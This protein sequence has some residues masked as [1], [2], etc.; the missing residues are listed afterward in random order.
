M[1]REA[2][3]PAHE[4]EK[5]PVKQE[6][7]SENVPVIKESENEEAIPSYR[8]LNEWLAAMTANEHVEDRDEKKDQL[9]PQDEEDLEETSAQY[10]SDEDWSFLAKDAP[11]NLRETSLIRPS[12]PR[13][14]KKTSPIRPYVR[15]SHQT[16]K[17]SPEQERRNTGHSHPPVPPPPCGGKGPPLGVSRRGFSLV[18]RMNLILALRLVF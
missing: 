3:D 9:S 12:S 10:H 1:I 4:F 13:S 8:Q 18:P 11:K 5:V 6:S 15:F 7:E 2:L 16:V 17:G 14:L